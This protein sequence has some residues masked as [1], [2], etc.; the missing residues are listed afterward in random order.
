MSKF[1]K[2]HGSVSIWFLDEDL[3][4]SAS[5]LTDKALEKS[6]KGCAGALVSTY[7]HMVGIR[8]KRMHE[9]LFSE[10]HRASTMSRLFPEWPG[11][12]VPSFAAYGKKE[13]KW[14]RMCHENFDYTAKY[15][16]SLLDERMF[17][18]PKTCCE[19][20]IWSW[21]MSAIDNVDFPYSGIDKVVL[22]WKALEPRWRR[23]DIIEGYRLQYISQLEDGDPFTAYSTCKRDIPKFIVEKCAL[24]M[25]FES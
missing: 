25:Q 4:V 15:L 3:D 20:D 23:T 11:H 21:V 2:K 9:Q 10:E 7:M 24:Q 16:R 13:S 6:V 14:C 5:Y 12:H 18:K 8:S 1:G 17:R 19:E 22:P